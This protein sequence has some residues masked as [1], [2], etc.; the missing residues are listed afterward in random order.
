MRLSPSYLGGA[1]YHFWVYSQ[2]LYTAVLFLSVWVPT[3]FP[4]TTLSPFQQILF[5]TH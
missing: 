3:T 5:L 1:S 4:I 2:K